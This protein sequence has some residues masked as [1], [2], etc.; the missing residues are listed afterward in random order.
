M[1]FENK[2]KP[3][4]L[5]MCYFL[6]MLNNHYSIIIFSVNIDHLFAS[7]AY[8]GF[9]KSRS[10]LNYGCFFSY[11]SSNESKRSILLLL[12]GNFIHQLTVS[13]DILNA[14]VFVA[15]LMQ[16]LILAVDDFLH[17]FDLVN[18]VVHFIVFEL[19]QDHH[20]S[21]TNYI[22]VELL[23]CSLA[24]GLGRHERGTFVGMLEDLFDLFIL[25]VF[26]EVLDILRSQ[27][28]NVAIEKVLMKDII[29]GAYLFYYLS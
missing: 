13:V 1:I 11:L 29:G 23:Q 18:E 4:F 25:E 24:G 6:E 19:L 26:L 28:A 9:E 8:D 10:I 22:A 7:P 21:D 12:F 2:R 15:Q 14:C 27:P 16:V 20:E 3:H 17:A 5:I